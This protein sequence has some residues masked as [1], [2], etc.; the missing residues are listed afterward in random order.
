M[1]EENKTTQDSLIKDLKSD[2]NRLQKLYGKLE[3]EYDDLCEKYNDL[4]NAFDESCE[5]RQLLFTRYADAYSEG[6]K[7]GQEDFQIKA[8]KIL[9]TFDKWEAYE[10]VNVFGVSTNIE[11]LND[12]KT[13]YEKII[14]YEKEKEQE[15]HVGDV[16]TQDGYNYIVIDV[17]DNDNTL[18]MITKSG[19]VITLH[20]NYV[21][22]TG[23]HYPIDEMLKEL[24]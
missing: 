14:A 9:D 1:T 21:K 12:I 23:K 6:F 3:S 5:H 22:K 20:K 18:A 10:L 4:Q 13:N 7:N 17:Y 19:A 24:E 8:K 11:L 15:I 2:R 16:V